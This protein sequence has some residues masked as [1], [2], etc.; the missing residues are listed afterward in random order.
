MVP[1][2]KIQD[3]GDISGLG[4]FQDAKWKIVCPFLQQQDVHS[5]ASQG[6]AEKGL[7][8]ILDISSH[9]VKLHNSIPLQSDPLNTYIIPRVTIEN[10]SVKHPLRMLVL[11]QLL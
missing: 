4:V 10:V 7:G 2:G 9:P 8:L 1:S 6:I 11:R 5:N 3:A